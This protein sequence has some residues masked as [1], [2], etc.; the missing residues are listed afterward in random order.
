MLIYH[1]IAQV[2]IKMMKIVFFLHLPTNKNFQSK[3]IKNNMPCI[4]ILIMDHFLDKMVM[5]LIFVTIPTHQM[6]IIQDY[7]ATNNLKI[8]E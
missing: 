1:G 5:I 7:Y 4:V 3:M 6:T 2:T 8:L